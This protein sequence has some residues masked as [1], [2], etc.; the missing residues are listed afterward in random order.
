MFEFWFG[1]SR[2]VA[3][4]LSL[5]TDLVT[6]LD[7][8][9]LPNQ[10]PQLVKKYSGPPLVFWYSLGIF[11]PC[12][13]SVWRVGL[14]L[15]RQRLR[16][17]LDISI[18]IQRSWIMSLTTLNIPSSPVKFLY[19][20]ISRNE[21]EISWKFDI[22]STFYQNLYASPVD[23]TDILIIILNYT[24]KHILLMTNYDEKKQLFIVLMFKNT[25]VYYYRWK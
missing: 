6:K 22:W 2:W 15:F 1:K 17:K 25:Y 20:R 5:R 12:K 19:E 18:W 23:I 11:A 21:D 10:I 3:A 14:S 16:P 8:H 4:V 24:N 7:L 9:L 13:A